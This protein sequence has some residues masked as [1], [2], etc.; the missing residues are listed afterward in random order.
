MAV[1]IVDFPMNSMV[2]FQSYMTVYQRVI[3][4]ENEWEKYD[5]F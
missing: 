1:E 2:I 5:L 4:M 3:A